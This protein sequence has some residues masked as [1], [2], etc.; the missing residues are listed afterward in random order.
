MN[1]IMWSSLLC[2]NV[3]V[4][5]DAPFT[6]TVLGVLKLRN[7]INLSKAGGPDVPECRTCN[8]NSTSF[9]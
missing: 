3:K 2:L 5:R 4:P 9:D 1:V 8:R 7:D 6:V